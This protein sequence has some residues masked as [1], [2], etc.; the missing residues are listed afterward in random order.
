M[1]PSP[2]P[3][4]RLRLCR[5]PRGPRLRG[6]PRRQRGKPHN[7]R[8]RWARLLLA[9]QWLGRPRETYRGRATSGSR[10]KHSARL[11]ARLL[12]APLAVPPVAA[13]KELAKAIKTRVKS[14]PLA[15]LGGKRV[16]AKRLAPLALRVLLVVEATP[17][18]RLLV[19]WPLQA[20]VARLPTEALTAPIQTQAPAQHLPPPLAPSPASV[21]PLW[22]VPAS[23]HL[24]LRQPAARGQR[25]R[26]GV[27]LP[28][29]VQPQALLL[30]ASVPRAPAAVS[31]GT[32]REAPQRRAAALRAPHQR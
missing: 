27:R 8:L 29:E 17:L 26:L 5:H 1:L 14:T 18:L 30:Q 16:L 32:T 13:F 25:R 22:A 21:H 12:A 2:I 6:P 11:R 4:A 23:Q 20:S 24:Q 10:G 9:R 28:A 7:Q 15:T 31:V 19:P 3:Q